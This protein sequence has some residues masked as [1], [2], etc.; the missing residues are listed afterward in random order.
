MMARTRGLAE[1]AAKLDGQ[2]VGQLQELLNRRYG[3]GPDSELFGP[4]SPELE[5]L[6]KS[7]LRLGEH[8]KDYLFW[9][10]LRSEGRF[11]NAPGL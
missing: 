8:L 10:Q 4:P 11:T 5:E 6:E 7:V 1:T 3:A 9:S 2:L